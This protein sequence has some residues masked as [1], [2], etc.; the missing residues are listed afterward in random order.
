MIA[1]DKQQVS[2][3]G[4]DAP[5]AQSSY[6][7]LKQVNGFYGESY[8]VQDVSFSLNKGEVIALLGRNG[9]GKTSTLKCIARADEPIV[10]SGEIW[11]DG[12]P[13][14]EMSAYEAARLGVQLV[15]EDRRIIP[16]LTVHENLELAQVAE[17]LG[18]KIE[19]IYE[20]FPR[21]GERRGQEAVTL[22]GGNS[23]CLPLAERL[24]EK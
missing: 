22:S 24:L 18:W 1:K 7:S 6:L 8:I 5:A 3:S 12:S 11:F 13:L 10:Q 2:H 16:G 23:K 14:H 17:P 15:P 9:A 4:G 21:L 20:R 19:R